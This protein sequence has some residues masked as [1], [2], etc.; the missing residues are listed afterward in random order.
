[1]VTADRFPYGNAVLIESPL[2]YSAS[3]TLSP[4]LPITPSPSPLTCPG[5]TT[6]S[7]SEGNQSVYILYA[8]MRSTDGL[9][10]GDEVGCGQ[11]LGE[12]GDTGNALNPHIHLE[13]RIGPADAA[14]ESMAHYT[15]SASP[16]EMDAYCAWRVSGAFQVQD[17]GVLFGFESTE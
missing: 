15:G 1:M 12:I 10:I 9:Q 5:T 7:W 3:Y 2:F 14:F 6:F 16:A 11:P 4:F 8:H 13:M 17:P